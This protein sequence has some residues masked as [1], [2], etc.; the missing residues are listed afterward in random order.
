MLSCVGFAL[1]SMMP[2]DIGISAGDTGGRKG[3]GLEE[4]KE[5]HWEPT[6]EPPTSPPAQNCDST[7][8]L[9]VTV[10]GNRQ[11][12]PQHPHL[13]QPSQRHRSTHISSGPAGGTAAPTPPARQGTRQH[14]VSSSPARCRRAA[15]PH[16]CP[17]SCRQAGSSASPPAA[18]AR[19]TAAAG[20]GTPPGKC[21]AGRIGQ[22]PEPTPNAPHAARSFLGPGVTVGHAGPRAPRRSQSTKESPD[23]PWD[24]SFS[25]PSTKRPATAS[26]LTPGW[27]PA[28]PA[29][30]GSGEREEKPQTHYALAAAT[31][32]PPCSPLTFTSFP[33]ISG[34]SPIFL[35]SSIRIS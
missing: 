18:G 11:Q 31:A 9:N 12:A 33:L 32:G 6:E 8:S 19:C 16:L 20:R 25:F 2:T 13:L 35:L 26:G 5:I 1:G 10:L 4:D 30:P 34:S 24:R 7:L 14:P 28:A 27:R 17:G 21:S 3:S 22:C 29:R 15:G 23:R